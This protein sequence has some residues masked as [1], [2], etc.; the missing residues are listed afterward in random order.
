MLGFDP[1]G[2]GHKICMQ[3]MAF[4]STLHGDIYSVA[5]SA[6][7]ELLDVGDP[8]TIFQATVIPNPDC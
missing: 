1:Q 8:N 6:L 3:R 5:A 7:N 4:F 2:I